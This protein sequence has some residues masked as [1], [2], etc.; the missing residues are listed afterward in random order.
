LARLYHLRGNL[1]FMLGDLA[2]CRE[3]HERALEHA[4]RASSPELEARALSGLGDAAYAEGRMVTAH[5]CYRRCVELARAHGLG[6]VEVA[7]LSMVSIA[8][9]YANDPR[10]TLEEA[11]AAIEGTARVGHLRAEVIAR[12]AAYMALHDMGEVGRA[13]EHLARAHEL[14]RRLKSRRLEAEVLLFWAQVQLA[15]GCREEALSSLHEGLAISRETGM[16]YIGPALLGALAITTG[17]PSERP[18][19]LAEGE[20]LLRRGSLSHNHLWFYRDAIEAAL[21]VD[22]WDEADRFASALEDY[23]RREELPWAN[24]L[25]TRARALAGF[26]RGRRD[27]GILRTLEQ[28]REGAERA[29]MR[30]AAVAI[31]QRLNDG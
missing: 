16:D 12:D 24:F 22:D 21:Q 26:G 29:G 30:V 13:A 19:V 1:Y 31:E 27:D 6:R 3:Q 23:T 5:E 2:A 4:R 18:R 28:L 9:Y 10:G 17:D 11:L 7:N 15:Q 25:V 14:A 20:G 8:R